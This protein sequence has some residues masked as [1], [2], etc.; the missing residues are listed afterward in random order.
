MKT[1]KPLRRSTTPIKRK[2]RVRPINRKRKAKTFARA[3]GGSARA[4]FVKG[5]ACIVGRIQEYPK[6][7]GDMVNAH[8]KG[9]GAGRK[10]D[11]RFCVPLCVYHHDQLHELQPRL[12]QLGYGVNLEEAA[13]AT[14]MAWQLVSNVR[15][16][17]QRGANHSNNND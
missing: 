13:K 11:A 3:Y 5:M 9:D 7:W 16:I 4:E 15:P 14:E 8:I 17:E 1:R 6:C 12:F 2:T 10:A